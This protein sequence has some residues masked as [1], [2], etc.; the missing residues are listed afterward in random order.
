MMSLICQMASFLL[1]ESLKMEKG[2][3]HTCPRGPNHLTFFGQ[4]EEAAAGF[5]IFL[6][7][8]LQEGGISLELHYHS[9]ISATVNSV[10]PLLK[11]LAKIDRQYVCPVVCRNKRL[12]CL[13]IKQSIYKLF[14]SFTRT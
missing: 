7:I 3:S 2:N 14:C 11:L 4:A 13:F 6:E 5:M 12:C 9:R 10:H 8:L 1:R